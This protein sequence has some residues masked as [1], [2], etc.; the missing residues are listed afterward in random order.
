MRCTARVFGKV[1]DDEIA[2]LAERS[3][4]LDAE[5]RASLGL[6]GR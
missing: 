1:T 6:S 3:E 5:I 2:A 4:K